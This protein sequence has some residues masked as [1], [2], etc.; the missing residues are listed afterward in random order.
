V[1]A[2]CRLCFLLAFYHLLGLLF[3]PEDGSSMFFQNTGEL[4][5]DYMVK[6]PQKTLLF[7]P[8]KY[9]LTSVKHRGQNIK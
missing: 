2:L 8:N 4:L 6:H 9:I 5:P 7:K 3:D 1:F